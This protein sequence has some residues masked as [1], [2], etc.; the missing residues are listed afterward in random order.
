MEKRYTV[1]LGA[2]LYAENDEQ[3]KAKAEKLAKLLQTLEDNSAQV[4]ELNETPYGYFT[5]REVGI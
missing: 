2:Y 4:I 5:N 3:A 1:K